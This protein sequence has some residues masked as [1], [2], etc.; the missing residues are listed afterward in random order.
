MMALCSSTVPLLR[1]FR[2]RKQQLSHS[3]LQFA[4]S[5]RSKHQAC[6]VVQD[7]DWKHDGFDQVVWLPA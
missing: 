4:F 6:L 1:H 2:S 3:H 7:S 5:W